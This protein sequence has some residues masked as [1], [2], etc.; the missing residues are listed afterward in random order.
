MPTG[1]KASGSQ[2][3][4]ESTHESKGKPGRP[5]NTQGPPPVKKY[6]TKKETQNMIPK[7]MIIKPKHI[8]EKQK[9]NI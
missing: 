9:G 3:N 7:R 4:P 1:E 2:D 5:S 6:K 8:G